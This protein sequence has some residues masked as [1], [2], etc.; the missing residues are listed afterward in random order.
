LYGPIVLAGELGREGL[1]RV[2]LY[3]KNQT[4]HV[5]VPTPRVPVLVND[6]NDLLRRVKPVPDRPLVFRTA[7]LARPSD[8][9][10]APFYQVHHQRYAVYWD[11]FSEAGWET[12]QAELAGAEGRARE[13]ARRV[14]DCVKIGDRDAEARHGMKG[15]RTQAG[16]YEGRNWRHAIS[17]GWFSY[18]VAVASATDTIL[19]ATFWGDDAGTRTFDILVDNQKLA[20]QKLDRNAPGRFFDV[21][22]PLA[23]DLTAGK[24]K[25]TVR[26][27]AH[28]DH[29]AGGVFG[30]A[31]LKPE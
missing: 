5:S 15:E 9:T 11:L 19:Q 26:F 21:R 13:L 28:P 20:T 8:V 22:W 18:E 27:Q 7:G 23:K 30:L 2:S 24:R 14:I 12:Y 10:L 4:D 31:T 6:G 25:I 3:A 17:G 29:T 1:D 16:A